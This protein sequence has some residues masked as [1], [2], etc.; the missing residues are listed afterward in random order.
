MMWA[1][2]ARSSEALTRKRHF[3]AP[4]AGELDWREQHQHQDSEDIHVAQ[5]R[6][7]LLK[8]RPNK[9]LPIERTKRM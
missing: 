8:V 1:H 2:A 4:R 5:D 7:H 9:G 3:N 6:A